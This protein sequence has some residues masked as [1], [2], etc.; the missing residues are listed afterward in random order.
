ML[1][2][3]S[4]ALIRK[5]IGRAMQSMACLNGEIMPAEAAKVPIWDRGYLFGDAIYEMLRIYR[6]RPWLE[7]E[8]FDRLRRSLEGLEFEPHDLGPL[9]ERCRE[10]LS[11]SRVQEGTLYIQISRGVAPRAHAFPDPPVH[12]TELIVVRPYDDAPTAALRESGASTV[13]HPD[14]RWKRCDIKTTNLLGNILALQTAKRVGAAE[15]IL[16]DSDGLVT[17]ATHSSVLWVRDGQLG[18]TPESHEILPG[19]TR[20]LT[21]TFGAAKAHSY[22]AA[23]ITLDELRDSDEVLLLGTTIEVL[24]VIS[25]D[26]KPIGDGKPGPVTRA[27]LDAYRR[28]VAEWLAAAPGGQTR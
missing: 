13:S 5:T 27:L 10:T 19:V 17:E 14:L 11:T 4:K 12:P 25:L 18:G 20:R 9:I 6:G 28:D 1:I 7:R 8:H 21:E 26:G 23:R 3:R 2:G 24:P 22:E 15:A 16:F